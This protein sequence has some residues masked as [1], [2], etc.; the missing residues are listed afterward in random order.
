MQFAF[1]ECSRMPFICIISLYRCYIQTAIHSGNSAVTKKRQWF[2][3]RYFFVCWKQSARIPNWK[4]GS[5][6]PTSRNVY[7]LPLARTLLSY[8][9]SI[10]HHREGD[11]IKQWYKIDRYERLIA[12]S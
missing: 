3:I 9:Q 12:E 11:T 4:Q 5:S 1:I 8:G 6:S 10:R 2:S 7:Y